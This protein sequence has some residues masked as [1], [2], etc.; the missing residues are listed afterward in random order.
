M[1]FA[2][3]TDECVHPATKAKPKVKL[4]PFPSVPTTE[5]LIL[6]CHPWHSE[7][8]NALSL[9]RSAVPTEKTQRE[10]KN[11]AAGGAKPSAPFP[12]S[13]SSSPLPHLAMCHLQVVW[14]GTW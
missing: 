6:L 3:A 12:L 9:T 4:A 5:G 8:P 2:V 11:L 10:R 7:R 13:T 14:E 1:S